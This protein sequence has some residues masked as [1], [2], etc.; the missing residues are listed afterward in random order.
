[1][2]MAVIQL[3]FTVVSILIIGY[4]Q[5]EKIKSLESTINNSN[6]VIS[7]FKDYLSIFDLD[8]VKK[9]IDLKLENKDLE[10]KNILSN[11]M[12]Q[13]EQFKAYYEMVVL[14]AGLLNFLPEQREDFID[15]YVHI[16]RNKSVLRDI[17]KS[18]NSKSL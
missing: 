15:K 10:F 16:E 5:R 4:W 2:E 18:Y 11:Q 8:E 1:M 17:I 3:I 7:Q 9:N 6:T 12:S 13:D 14:N